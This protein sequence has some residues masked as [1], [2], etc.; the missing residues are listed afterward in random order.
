L[1]EK[2]GGC[3]SAQEVGYKQAQTSSVM[4]ALKFKY[5]NW[6]Y[7][8]LTKIDTCQH[9]DPK[10]NTDVIVFSNMLGMMPEAISK[11]S[12]HLMI[13]TPLKQSFVVSKLW[14]HDITGLLE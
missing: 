1:W 8:W 9:V 2:K 13:G 6:Y 11:V 7:G 10:S 3:F 12:C 4:L 5:I 14:H